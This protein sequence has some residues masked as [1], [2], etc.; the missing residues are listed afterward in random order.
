MKKGIKG[1]YLIERIEAEPCEKR[2]YVGQAIDIFSRL[3]QHCTQNNPGIDNAIAEFGAD[4]FSFRVL[5]IVN[6]AEDLNACETKWINHYKDQYSDERMYNIAQTA[7]SR[8][9]IDPLIKA[10]IKELFEEDLGRSIYAIAEYFDISHEEVIKIRRPFL[11]KHGLIWKGKIVYKST[12]LEPSNW[13]GGLITEKMAKEVDSILSIKG[14]TEKDIR[15]VSQSDLKIYLDSRDSYQYAS[16]I[17]NTVCSLY[18]K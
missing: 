5:E 10:K 3:N 13:R 4:K 12:G 15:F 2:Y 7:N 17:T 16:E 18:Q 9:S 14:N 1:I 8:T 11:S 6:H